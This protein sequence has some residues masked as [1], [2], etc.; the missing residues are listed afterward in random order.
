MNDTETKQAQPM[1]PDQDDFTLH[2]PRPLAVHVKLKLFAGKKKN[3][4]R[5][6]TGP[7]IYKIR[8]V[9]SPY[10]QV[11]RGYRIL[12][13]LPNME[14]RKPFVGTPAPT[15]IR[16]YLIFQTSDYTEQEIGRA[17]ELMIK[18]LQRR[19]F[20]KVETSE[21]YETRM[22]QVMGYRGLD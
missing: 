14:G 11:F 19:G 21:D 4:S 5:Q 16:P 15:F 17:E 22:L 8:E 7:C 9:L 1:D 10:Q 12:I 18:E 13:A 2:Q 6:W 3:L 20:T